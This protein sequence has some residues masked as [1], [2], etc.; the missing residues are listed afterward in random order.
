MRSVKCAARRRV[1]SYISGR[2]GYIAGRMFYWDYQRARERDL[3]VGRSFRRPADMTGTSGEIRY[4][5]VYA[6]PE[7]L[8]ESAGETR[9]NYRAA[10]C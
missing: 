1:H 7:I 4:T 6:T 5:F 8:N 10:R 9:N 3:N 2:F